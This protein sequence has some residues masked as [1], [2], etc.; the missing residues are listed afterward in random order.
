[1]RA[2]RRRFLQTTLAAGWLGATA[3]HGRADDRP[4][5]TLQQLDA[6]AAR[7]VLQVPQLKSPVTIA[8]I[9]LM[10]NGRTFLV[11]ARSKDGAEG[12]TVANDDRLNDLYLILIRRV[13]PY[14]LGKDARELDSLVDGVYLHD[15]N[16]KMQG[17]ALWVC[18]ASVEFALLDMLGKLTG[19]PI[20]DL[21]SCGTSTLRCKDGIVRVPS[22]PGSGITLDTE[23]VRRAELVRSIRLCR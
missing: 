10:H 23:F 2:H 20:G 17:L 11:R 22:G 3:R 18:V 6:A 7:P 8:S 12:L 19:K 15:S 16:Y 21:F 1:M 4:K 9:E 14:C 13:V 5:V